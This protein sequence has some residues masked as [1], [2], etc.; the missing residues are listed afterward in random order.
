M[1]ANVLKLMIISIQP[2]TMVSTILKNLSK[3][4]LLLDSYLQTHFCKKSSLVVS[5]TQFVNYYYSL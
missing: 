1:L 4:H 3:L 2:Q 5:N